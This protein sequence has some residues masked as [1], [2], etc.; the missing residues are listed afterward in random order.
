MIGQ[1]LSEGWKRHASSSSTA[2]RFCDGSLQGLRWSADFLGGWVWLTRW[3]DSSTRSAPDFGAWTQAVKQSVPH[4]LGAVLQ[5]RPHRG[6][7]PHPELL[8]GEEP[9]T[10]LIVSEDLGGAKLLARVRFAGFSH[11]G[12][13][14]DHAPLRRWV[15]AHSRGERILNTFAYTGL[16]GVAAGLGGAT[17]VLNADLSKKTLAWA[18]DNA[19]LNGLSASVKSIAVD[20]MKD[21]KIRSKKGEHFG[22]VILD[23][24]SFSRSKTSVFSTDKDLGQ[25][26]E[27]AFGC[28]RDGGWLSTSINS[29]SVSYRAYEAQVMQAARTARVR[30]EQVFEIAPPAPFPSD[31]VKGWVF[32]IKR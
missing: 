22:G 7:P 29:V 16:I 23:P 2:F 14:L 17:E 20:S 15:F 1:W 30:L 32:Q 5:S 27:L 24:P 18:D 26:H 9:P 21:L 11:P 10:G 6:A 13:F 25:L 4:A 12:I 28:V 31:H 19:A 8:F 3:E